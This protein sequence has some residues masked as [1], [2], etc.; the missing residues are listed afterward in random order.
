MKLKLFPVV[1]FSTLLFCLIQFSC[2]K[3]DNPTTIDYSQEIQTM[4]DAKWSEYWVGKDNPVGGFMMK[5]SSPQGDYFASANFNDSVNQHFHFRGASTTKTFT[6]AAIMLLNQQG[7]LRINDLVTDM[8]PD[9]S[10]PYLPATSDFDIPYKDQ[11]TIKYLLQHRAGV[12]DLVNDP[13]PDTVNEPYKGMPYA[14]YVIDILGDTYHTFTYNEWAS[15]ISKHHLAYFK[16]DSAFH[17]SDIGYNLLGLIIERVSGMSFEEFV[18]QQ[19]LDPNGLTET[20]S[21][22]L[23]TIYWLPD[24]FVRGYIWSEQYGI[25]EVT[26]MSNPS[27]DVAAGNVITTSYDLNRWIKKLIRGEA[28]LSRETVDEMMD[29]LET[30][31]HHQ[32]YGLGINYTPDLG[33]GHNGATAGYMTVMRYNPDTQVSFTI[34]ASFWHLEGIYP[35]A[36]CLYNIAHETNKILGYE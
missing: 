6:A 20:S 23:G 7:K 22:S 19:L 13:V 5:I 2:K 28:G 32:Y 10:E 18:K 9:Q 17:Y 30:F 12:F 31:E 34:I 14:A 27:I 36:N 4:L 25:F 1:L 8:I 15:I 11:I 26:T 35:E 3:K 21:P 24:P 33:Y 29:Y 16:P